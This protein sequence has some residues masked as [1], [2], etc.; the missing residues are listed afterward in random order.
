MFSTQNTTHTHTGQKKGRERGDGAGQGKAV[1]ERE[2][3]DAR[4]R[5]FR[6]RCN[7]ELLPFLRRDF[8]VAVDDGAVADG[9][10][11]VAVDGLR[12]RRRNGELVKEIA[13]VVVEY[14]DAVAVAVESPSHNRR[15]VLRR[16]ASGRRKSVVVIGNRHW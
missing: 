6:R 8:T 3:S 4:R 7:S 9:K 10:A 12:R 15:C 14:G 16:R 1:A 2:R 13:T 5:R 11:S